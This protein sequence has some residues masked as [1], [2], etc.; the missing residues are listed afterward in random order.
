MQ[1]LAG[2]WQSLIEAFTGGD[3]GIFTSLQRTYQEQGP[4]KASRGM[5]DPGAMSYMQ[6]ALEIRAS[7]D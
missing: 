6:Q 1:E 2:R 4:E 3:P 5:V 7:K